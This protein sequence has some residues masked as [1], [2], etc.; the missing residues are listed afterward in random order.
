[1][2]GEYSFLIQEILR[3]LMKVFKQAKKQVIKPLDKKEAAKLLVMEVVAITILS[4]RT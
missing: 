2:A 1:M 4:K 3:L